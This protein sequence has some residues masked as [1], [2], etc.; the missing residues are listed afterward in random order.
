M[1][2]QA[3]HAYLESCQTAMNVMYVCEWPDEYPGSDDEGAAYREGQAAAEDADCHEDD[4]DG[5]EACV[6]TS[7]HKLLETIES[8]ICKTSND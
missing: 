7:I 3:G 4:E 2:G 6:L 1:K 5:E 8:L